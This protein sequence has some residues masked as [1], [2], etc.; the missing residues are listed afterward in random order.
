MSRKKTTEKPTPEAPQAVNAC[1]SCGGELADYDDYVFH[2]ALRFGGAAIPVAA[3]ICA[4]WAPIFF[5]ARLVIGGAIGQVGAAALLGLIVKKIIAGA[6]VGV[7]LGAAVG[8]GRDGAG[9]L[10]GAITGSLAGFFFAAC[11]AMPLLSDASHRMDIVLTSVISALL[12]SATVYYTNAR[13]S[14]KNAAYLGP[15]PREEEKQ[16]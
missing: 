2:R 7:L 6:I 15:E 8:I 4:A 13:V 5:L 9:L 12:C 10:L 16:N 3:M 14:E 11:D 1:S